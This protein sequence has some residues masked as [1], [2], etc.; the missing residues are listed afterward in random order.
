MSNVAMVTDSCASIPEDML[1]QLYIHWVPYYIHRGQKALR[2]LVTVKDDSFYR[3]LATAV[4][5]PTT[6]VPG[7]GVGRI[8]GQA[9][10]GCV[11]TRFK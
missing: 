1:T 9:R 8:L 2:D 10:P 4:P 3:W 5:L 6:A 11:I 7:P